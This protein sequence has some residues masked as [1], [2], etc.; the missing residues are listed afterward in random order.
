M[1][2][3]GYF[4]G[5][6]RGNAGTGETIE[7]YGFAMVTVNENLKIQSIEVFFKP[8]EFIEVLEGKRQASELAKGKQIVGSGCPFLKD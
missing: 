6:F 5:N 1:A 4:N 7:M 2:S 8:D 3:L